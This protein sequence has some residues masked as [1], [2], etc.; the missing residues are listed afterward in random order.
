[1]IVDVHAHV[2]VAEVTRDWR[3]AGPGTAGAGPGVAAGGGLPEGWRPLVRRDGDGQ[4]VE[5]RGRSIRSA[6]GEFVDVDRMLEEAAACGVDRLVLS[7]WVNLLPYDLDPPAAL[8]ACRVQN[9]ALAE[10]CAA[11]PDR[12]GAL[13]AVPLQDPTVAAAELER[14]MGERVL[15]GVE[16]AASVAGTWLGDDRFLP[17]WEAAEATAAVVLVHPTTRGF[18]LPVLEQ[19]YL[20]NTVGN[21]LETAV[22][23]A[24]LVMAAVLERFP[25]LRVVLAHGGGALP[26]VRGRLRKAHSFQPQARARLTEP[27]DASLRRLY[28]DTVTHDPGLLRDLLAYAGPGHV[29]LGSDRPFDMGT[30]DPV[31]EVRALGL[32]PDAERAVLGGNAAALLGLGSG[33][34]AAR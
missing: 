21:P 34:A 23:G 13:G 15:G 30:A 5:F 31:G 28:Y 26:A 24:H 4:V 19:H 20:W 18:D 33:E 7:P 27:P 1:V 25:R 8:H 6:V 17:F 10:R 29:L 9:D 14:L 11:H 3:P 12:V 16:V 32:D 22:A 2:I